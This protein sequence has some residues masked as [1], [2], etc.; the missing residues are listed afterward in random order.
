MR[1][2]KI[3]LLIPILSASL[4]ISAQACHLEKDNWMAGHKHSSDNGIFAMTEN[5]TATVSTTTNCDWYTLFLEKEYEFLAE[6]VAQGQ[7]EHLIALAEFNGCSRESYGT[8]GKVLKKNHGALFDYS[9]HENHQLLSRRVNSLI[10]S[11]EY[12]SSQCN[13]L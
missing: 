7:G 5:L 11:D 4:W 6:E 8:F 13:Q 9:S 1:I 12:L 10:V 2:L 3:I